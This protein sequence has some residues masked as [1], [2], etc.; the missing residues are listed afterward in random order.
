MA[1]LDLVFWPA[2]VRLHAFEDHVRAASAGGF[3][4]LAIASTTYADARAR[5]L[6]TSDIRRMAEDGGVPLRHL[7]TLTT[8]APLQLDYPF[9]KELS[10]RVNTTIDR[11][12]DICAELGLSQ[13]LATAGYLK[14]GV[15][16]QQLIDGFGD[17]CQ[18]AA[19]LGIWVDLEPMP[20]FGCNNVAAAWAV[21]GGAAQENSGILMDTWHFYKADQTLD[22]IANIPGRYFHTMQINDAP[23]A[24]ISETLIEDTIKYRRWPGQGEL[25]VTEFMQAIFAKGGIVAVGQEVFSLEADQMAPETAGRIAGETTRAALKTAGIPVIDLI[26]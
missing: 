6:S 9:D 3:T 26:R 5:G 18:R 8:W 15:P 4:S 10:E 11:G 17:L 20:F 21:V 19:N 16:L 7:D 24:Q 1:Q 23:I 22:V 13:I 14:D 25:P 12:L 2:P